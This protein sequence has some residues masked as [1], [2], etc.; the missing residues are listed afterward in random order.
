MPRVCI[1]SNNS[2]SLKKIEEIIEHTKILKRQR[3]LMYG[4]WDFVVFGPKG[5]N[6][7]IIREG[8]AQH[9]KIVNSSVYIASIGNPNHVKHNGIPIEDFMKGDV[10][11]D[12]EGLEIYQIDPLRP[13]TI[14]MKKEG[15]LLKKT[16]ALVQKE[17][18]DKNIAI[19]QTPDEGY[20]GISVLKYLNECDTFFPDA[21]TEALKKGT[22]PIDARFIDLEGLIG[23]SNSMIH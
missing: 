19:I 3:E 13:L 22:L 5:R 14:S 6:K 8:N 12:L 18:E 11:T 9:V 21:L 2:D 1:R 17:Y 7:T 10:P 4:R 23:G 16:V 15:P 20:W